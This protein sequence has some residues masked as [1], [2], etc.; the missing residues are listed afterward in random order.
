MSEHD[1]YLLSP[2]LTEELSRMRPPF[3]LVNLLGADLSARLIAACCKQAPSVSLQQFI[4]DRL[5]AAIK[6]DAP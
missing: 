1:P 5:E 3:T 2:K 6:E 4:R